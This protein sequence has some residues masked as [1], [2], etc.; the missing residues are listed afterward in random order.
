MVDT[1]VR[2]MDTKEKK[3]I[4]KLSKKPTELLTKLDE[5][6]ETK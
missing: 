3:E 4:D 2:L 5:I 1:Y 6:F